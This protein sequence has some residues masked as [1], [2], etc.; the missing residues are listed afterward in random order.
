M[1][2]SI[3]PIPQSQSSV[4]WSIPVHDKYLNF[5]REIEGNQS[6][7]LHLSKGGFITWEGK[8]KDP[9]WGEARYG[10]DEHNHICIS[11]RARTGETKGH[12]YFYVSLFPDGKDENLK[13]FAKEIL[14][15]IHHK[16][17]L[18]TLKK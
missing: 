10:T 5:G 13:T 15:K 4:D 9:L 6:S 11:G 1:Y 8:V 7:N 12:T 14:P 17:Y 2:K 3:V 18:R 16:L